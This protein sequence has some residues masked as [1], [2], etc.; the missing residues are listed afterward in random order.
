MIA[1]GILFKEKFDMS[2][3]ED[4][5]IINQYNPSDPWTESEDINDIKKKTV[6]GD[7]VKIVSYQSD[8]LEMIKQIL[9]SARSMEFAAKKLIKVVEINEKMFLVAYP[10]FPEHSECDDDFEC[11]GD[12]E[13]CE[14]FNKETEEGDS[15]EIIEIS[16]EDF[17]KFKKEFEESVE[18][19]FFSLNEK[20]E[21]TVKEIARV[22]MFL[23]KVTYSEEEWFD[24]LKDYVDLCYKFYPESVDAKLVQEMT[25]SKG[26]DLEDLSVFESIDELLNS[27]EFD[28]RLKSL[29]EDMFDKKNKDKKDDDNNEDNNK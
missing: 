18:E 6:F 1:S 14:K 3:K 5:D 7:D 12:C 10:F 22:S 13:N 15:D 24:K 2:S 20:I 28:D 16:P 29:F 17:D 11:T 9:K 23:L 26:L 25:F 4:I 21:N 19:S 8:N 27:K